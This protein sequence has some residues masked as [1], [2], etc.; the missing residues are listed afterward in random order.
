MAGNVY[1]WCHDGTVQV[2]SSDPVSDP[3]IDPDG[4]KNRI[5]RGGSYDGQP[6]FL[7]A[8]NRAGWQ[9]TTSIANRGMRCV[10]TK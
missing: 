6:G 10:R 4:K 8:A 9:P 2:L 5:I 7:R 3:V 1:E